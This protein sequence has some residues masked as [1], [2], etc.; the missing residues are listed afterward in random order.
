MELTNEEKKRLY[1][2]F[3]KGVTVTKEKW[4]RQTNSS[5]LLIDGT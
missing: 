1:S 2:I 4:T 5:I 3:Q